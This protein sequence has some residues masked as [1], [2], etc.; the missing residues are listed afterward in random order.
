MNESEYYRCPSS[1]CRDVFPKHGTTLGTF[2][3]HIRK[4]GLISCM[5]HGWVEGPFCAT[6]LERPAPKPPPEPEPEPLPLDHSAPV[7]SWWRK[8]PPD[9]VRLIEEDGYDPYTFLDFEQANGARPEYLNALE[10]LTVNG[11]A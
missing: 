4:H 11:L 7:P 6:C 10:R 9:L 5:R 8:A 3:D 2:H 1:A